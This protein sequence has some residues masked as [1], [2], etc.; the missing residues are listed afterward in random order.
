MAAEQSESYFKIKAHS[1]GECQSPVAEIRRADGTQPRFF[2]FDKEIFPRKN[3]TIGFSYD[4]INFYA[5]L[6]YS[7]NPA[8]FAELK[9]VII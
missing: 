1:G 3:N 5:N 8:I 9:C 4:L 6:V 7:T 2:S